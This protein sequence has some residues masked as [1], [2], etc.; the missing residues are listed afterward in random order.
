[1]AGM[2]KSSPRLENRTNKIV[3]RMR[4]DITSEKVDSLTTTN[5]TAMK[6]RIVA[7]RDEALLDKIFELN[8]HG[9][10]SG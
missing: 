8:G 10:Q 3:R 5:N 2:M 4:V 1:M 6:N 7:G 9:A